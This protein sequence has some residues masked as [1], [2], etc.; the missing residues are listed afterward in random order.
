MSKSQETQGRKNRPS[1]CREVAAVKRI[2][3]ESG[4]IKLARL[5]VRLR[6]AG[7]YLA[8][9]TVSARV[10]DLRK[11]EFGGHDVRRRYAGDG[12]WEYKLFPRKRKA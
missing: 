12:L 10:R 7:I 2:M 3:R 8:E 1:K 11:D 4:W 9:Q 6:I 5:Q